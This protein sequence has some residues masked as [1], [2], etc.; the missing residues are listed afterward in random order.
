MGAK[1]STAAAVCPPPPKKKRQAG[2][3]KREPPKNGYFRPPDL[4][5][6]FAVPQ[7]R[8]AYAQHCMCSEKGKTQ[9]NHDN[10]LESTLEHELKIPS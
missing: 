4:D 3:A 2:G 10:E 5:L 7:R 1:I 6:L 8:Y 9:D